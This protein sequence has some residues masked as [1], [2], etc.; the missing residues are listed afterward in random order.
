MSI[1]TNCTH[2]IGEPVSHCELGP[3]QFSSCLRANVEVLEQEAE[4]VPQDCD[5]NCVLCSTK[6]ADYLDYYCS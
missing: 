2:W 6:C 5:G 4:A 1:C 3:N